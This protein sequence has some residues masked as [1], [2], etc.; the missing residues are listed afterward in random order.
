MKD[1]KGGYKDWR[2]LNTLPV[3][4]GQ[5]DFGRFFEFLNK[6]GYDGM[7]TVESTA[8]DS[9]GVVDVEMLN[10]QFTTIRDLIKRERKE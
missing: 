7:Y 8:F 6:T 2:N 4:K 10:E 9:S 1:Y 3:G 5:I